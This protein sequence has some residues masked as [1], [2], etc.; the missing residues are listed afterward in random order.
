MV[1]VNRRLFLTGVSSLIAA[2]AIVRY[3]SI[4]PVKRILTDKVFL[5]LEDPKFSLWTP[6]E[7][8]GDATLLFKMEGEKRI[9]SVVYKTEGSPFIKRLPDN[10]VFYHD[11]YKNL[12]VGY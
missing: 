8:S 9:F 7:R 4:M 3:S 5:H 12:L 1:E 10:F 2:P 6:L 11:N